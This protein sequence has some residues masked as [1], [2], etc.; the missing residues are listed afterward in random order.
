MRISQGRSGR[1]LDSRERALEVPVGLQKRLLGQVL[2]VVMVADPVVAVGV[3]VP[4]VRL[5]QLRK[6]PVE[7]G[8][9]HAFSL[10]SAS[11]DHPRADDPARLGDLVGERPW[12]CPRR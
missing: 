10:P 12:R 11:S 9:V 8:L 2:G 6:A 5:V 3:D 4:Q 7:L 1:P